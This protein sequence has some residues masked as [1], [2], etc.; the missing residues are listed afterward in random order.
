MT[1]PM[2]LPT[3]PPPPDR[4]ESCRLWNLQGGLQIRWD[5]RLGEY[6]STTGDRL[7]AGTVEERVGQLV[8]RQDG[9]G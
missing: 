8:R 2:S 6:T 4:K 5:S 1:L 3:A 9:N 7:V